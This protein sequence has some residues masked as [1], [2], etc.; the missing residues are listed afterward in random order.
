MDSQQTRVIKSRWGRKQYEIE[1]LA[2]KE[3]QQE[4][5]QEME[6][7]LQYNF[8]AFRKHRCKKKRHGKR[9][10]AGGRIKEGRKQLIKTGA[11]KVVEE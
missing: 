5:Q 4:F 6:N 3:T 10:N 7:I 11:S 8:L 9:D 1:T 2:R